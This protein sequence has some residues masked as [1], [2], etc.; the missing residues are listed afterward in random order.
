MPSF[1]AR[2]HIPGQT[3]LPVT[4]VVD[5]SDEE[6]VITSGQEILGVWPLQGIKVES[7]AD[8]FHLTLDQ[9]EI[10]LSVA[11]AARFASQL[12]V[13]HQDGEQRRRNRAAQEGHD[14][15]ATET[16]GLGKRV[17][18]SRRLEEVDI[19]ERFADVRRRISALATALT[20]ES[21]SP[22]DLFGRW[23]RLLKEINLQHGQGAMPTPLFYRFNTELLDL[24]P[25]PSGPLPAQ[26]V[27]SMEQSS[28]P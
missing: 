22:S 13:E 17:G 8:G 12:G 21:V 20:D 14:P 10:I 23:L 28:Q 15:S 9:E 5:V 27:E 24:I 26:V 19:E 16:H 18:I 3:R 7:H 11:D 6:I 2:L 1:D 4:V 25:A